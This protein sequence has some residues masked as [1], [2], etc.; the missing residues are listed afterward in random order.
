M[1]DQILTELKQFLTIISFSMLLY[2]FLVTK[3]SRKI[4]RLAIT[5]SI[6]LKMRVI[7]PYLCN[8][9]N[10]PGIPDGKG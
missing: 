7:T 4:F 1:N 6:T 9:Q 3:F 5:F 8:F 2:T 10:Y